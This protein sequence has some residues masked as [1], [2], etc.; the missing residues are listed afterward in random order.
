MEK[1]FKAI[2]KRLKEFGDANTTSK[3]ETEKY[4]E[5][6]ECIMDVHMNNIKGKEAKK[7]MMGYLEQGVKDNA[8]LVAE[9]LSEKAPEFAVGV[10]GLGVT[11]MTRDMALAATGTDNQYAYIADA[12]DR[13]EEYEE[14]QDYL[15]TVVRGTFGWED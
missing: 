6:H 9:Y 8:P 11:K 13:F 15:G 5:V 4:A 12:L 3:K 10:M 7:Y 2:D 14:V 1:Y